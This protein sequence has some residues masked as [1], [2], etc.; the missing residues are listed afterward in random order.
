VHTTTLRSD[1]FELTIDGQ[2]GSERAEAFVTEMLASDEADLSAHA[3]RGGL[4]E[5]DRPSLESF[6]RIA[7]P[8]ALGML[9]SIKG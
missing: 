3:R 6:R 1:E 4:R 5:A 7:L 2:P 9:G 8:G